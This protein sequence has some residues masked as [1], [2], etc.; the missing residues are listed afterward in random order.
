MGVILNKQKNKALDFIE[1]IIEAEIGYIFTNN[2]NYEQYL[3]ESTK[4]EEKTQLAKENPIII[5][6]RKRIN[7]YYK[8]V[9]INL[10]DLIPKNIKY[11]LLMEANKKIE[12]EVFQTINNQ[13]NI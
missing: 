8:V 2:K 12:F 6:L 1:K 7:A 10:R 13:D 3:E 4:K 11:L 5:V 9:V